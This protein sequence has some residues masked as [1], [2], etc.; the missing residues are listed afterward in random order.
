MTANIPAGDPSAFS[1]EFWTLANIVTAFAVVQMI[2]YA[3]AL[4]ATGSTILAGVIS[5]RA[6]VVTFIVVATLLYCATTSYFSWCHWTLLGVHEGDLYRMLQLTMWMRMFVI[7]A[8]GLG[9]AIVTNI[10]RL[11]SP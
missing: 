9:G 11:P 6:Y 4:G 2:A 7:A 5:I 1:N 3:M 10:I 8:A